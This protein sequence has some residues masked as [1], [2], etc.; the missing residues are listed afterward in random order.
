V[1]KDWR[2]RPLDDLLQ[3]HGLDGTPERPF[4]NDGWSG[5]R[6]TVLERDRKRFILKRTSWATDWIVRATRDQT[7]RE[8]WIAANRPRVL[9]PM[10]APYLGSAVDRDCAVLLMPDLSGDLIAWERPAHELG[11][12]IP[13]LDRVLE[14]MARL[15]FTPWSPRVASETFPWCPLPER[16]LLLSRPSAERYRA[17]GL[18]VGDRFIEGWDAFDRQAPASVRELL[19]AIADEPDPLLR[20]LGRLPHVGLHGDMKLANV[21]LANDGVGIIDW[22][23]TTVAPVAVE[24]GWF[25]V[26]NVALLPQPPDLV[27]ER[28]LGWARWHADRFAGGNDGPPRRSVQ[29]VIDDWEAQTDLAWVVGLLLRGWRKGLDAEAGVRTGWGASGSED[30]AWWSRRAVEAA[31]RRL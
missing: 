7:L 28:Y 30:L 23:M 6:L 9:G 27:L 15:H 2:E 29:L 18:A 1:L 22:Q 3:A 17:D 20:A 21:A 31:E 24:L 14:A 25:L 13:T 10:V 12:D 26:S 4:P 5:S 16:L 8:A 11:I 19:G